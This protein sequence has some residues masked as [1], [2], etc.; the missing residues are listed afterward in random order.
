MWG[1]ASPD[2]AMA[3]EGFATFLGGQLGWDASPPDSVGRQQSIARKRAG[4]YNF[5]QVPWNLE[6][7]LLF[8]YMTC[9]DSFLQ[10]VTFMPL[11]VLGALLS[12]LRGRRL[13]YAQSGIY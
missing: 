5:L 6:P 7:L 12:L 4:V 13:S 9:L 11:R 8:G 2:A 3:R 10:L 1:N